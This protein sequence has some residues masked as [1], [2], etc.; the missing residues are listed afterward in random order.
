MAKKKTYKMP[1]PAEN[2]VSEPAIAYGEMNIL[3]QELIDDI[4]Q[5]NDMIAL[6]RLVKYIRR[7]KKAVEKETI[8]KEEILAGI[9][10]SLTELELI[11]AGKK[12][13]KDI[14][15]FLDELQD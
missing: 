12:K 6:K 11:R 5:L 3:K 13:A 4:K 1:P 7:Q 10:A 8:G 2:E 9:E 14:N 15:E